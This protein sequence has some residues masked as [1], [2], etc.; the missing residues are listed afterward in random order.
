MP[1]RKCDARGHIYPGEV[2]SPR[3]DDDSTGEGRAAQS[4]SQ[5][6]D[7]DKM[8]REE[9]TA[10]GQSR[11]RAR[12][13]L[14]DKEIFLS[15]R[16]VLGLRGLPVYSV[17]ECRSTLSFFS[18]TVGIIGPQSSQGDNTAAGCSSL[19]FLYSAGILCCGF[20]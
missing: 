5:V 1:A 6:P 20:A 13:R 10:N 18:S 4:P 14:Q 3:A 7:A 12:I 15:V 2:L 9:G 19:A 16:T 11:L 8:A 17:S